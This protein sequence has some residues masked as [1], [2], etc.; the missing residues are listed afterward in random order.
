VPYVA[1]RSDPLTLLIDFRNVAADAVTS[2]VAP[3]VQSAIESVAVEQAE[4]GGDASGVVGARIRIKLSEPVG[5]RARASRNTVVID[6]DKSEKSDKKSKT[7]P[8]VLPPTTRAANAAGAGQ[9]PLLSRVDSKAVDPI[10]ALGLNTDA[11]RPKTAPASAAANAQA[12]QGRV[13]A[14]LAQAPAPQ[15]AVQAQ[16]PEQTLPGVARAGERRFTGN[17]VSLD[18]Q[19]ADLRAVLRTF[20][21]ISGLNIVI[22]P[23][24]SGSVDVALRDVPWDQALDIILRANKL[25][26]LVDGTIVRIAPLTV[27]SEEESQRRKLTDEQALAGEL[28]VLTKTLSYAKAEELTPLLTKSALSQRGTVN[29]DVRTNTLIITDL[30]DRLTTATDLINTLDRAQPQVEIEARI[31]QVNKNFQRNLGVQW[32]FNGRIDPTLG[33]TTNLAFPNSGALAGATGGVTGGPGG[34]ATAVNLPVQGATSGVGLRLGSV[35]GAFNLDVA[36]T[37]LETSGNGR[38]LSTPRVSTQNNVEAEIKQGTQIPIQTVAN[39]TVTVQFK[40]AALVLK[41]T[42]QITAANTVIMKISLE[43]GQADFSRAVNGIPPINT[44][45]ANTSVLVNDGQTTV[46]GGIYLSTEQYSTDR[47]PG[48]G[49]VPVIGWLFKRENAQD[50]STELLIFITPRITKS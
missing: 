12:T 35:N 6:F 36:L 19:G 21:E 17:P 16:A 22:D 29:F 5:Y 41:V 38:V 27:L 24:V 4:A 42:P 46:I 23:A 44:Q 49:H 18:F 31:V 50:S 37:A 45:S 48:L 10:A 25:G 39:N 28:R 15:P 1:T 13:G 14:A 3:D 47:T 2:T 8:Y 20:S 26:Y 7:P 40:D 43:N 30:P 33:N 9:D 32:G 11:S 34:T